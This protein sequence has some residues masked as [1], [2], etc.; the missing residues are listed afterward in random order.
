MLK[1][2]IEKKKEGS[3][4]VFHASSSIMMSQTFYLYIE[5]VPCVLSRT[6]LV[7]IS[8]RTVDQNSKIGLLRSGDTDY[9]NFMDMKR[10]R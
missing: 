9:S 6:E 4:V 5:T 2:S 10:M 1:E 7:Q 8:D 3:N